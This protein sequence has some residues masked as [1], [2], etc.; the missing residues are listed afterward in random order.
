[1]RPMSVYPA[2]LFLRWGMSA[3][4]VTALC[5]VMGIVACGFMSYGYYWSMIVAA[6]LVN[7]RSVLDYSD[8]TVA[9]ATNNCTDYGKFLDRICDDIMGMLIPIAI[10][11]GLYFQPDN[12][13]SFLMFGVGIPPMTFLLMGLVYSVLST[14]SSVVSDEMA[15]VFKIIPSEFYRPK[16][17]ED[18][19]LWGIIYKAGINIQPLSTLL[20]LVFAV[21][22]A[23]S[24]F[25]AFY[26]VITLC[27]VVVAVGK[28]ILALPEKVKE[29]VY[30]GKQ[31]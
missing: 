1:M 7:V 24:V 14:F 6:F 29:E 3:N 18:K 10:G 15:L 23:M 11:V 2:W 4:K 27:E 5:F 13:L 9:R 31:Y 25:L 30:V 20:M 12:S 22:N 21:C 17:G 28:R 26:T 19:S 8:G 16:E